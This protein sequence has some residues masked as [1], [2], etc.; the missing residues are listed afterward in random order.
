MARRASLLFAALLLS[1]ISILA[2]STG[3]VAQPENATAQPAAVLGTENGVKVTSEGCVLEGTEPL[4]TTKS[5]R[6][7]M[8]EASAQG[9]KSN[10]CLD[11]VFER[12]IKTNPEEATKSALAFL[13]C[14]ELKDPAIEAGCHPIAHAIGRG[15]F[16]AVQTVSDS[17]N[18]CDQTCHSGCYHG[19]MER[20]LRGDS[21]NGN[22]HLSP[23]ELTVK[24]KQ[25]CDP[26]EDFQ[27]RFQCLHG[28]GHALMYYLRTPPPERYDLRNSLKICDELGD[29]WSADSCWGGVFMENVSPAE[30][31]L[32]DVT[33]DPH[34]P[35]NALD[36]KYKGSCYQMQTSR[37]FQLGIGRND[38]LGHCRNAGAYRITCAESLGRDISNDV[39]TGDGEGVA[40]SCEAGTE[41]E[42]F[43]CLRGAVR[44]VIDNTWDGRFALPFCPKF[45]SPAAVAHCFEVSLGYLAGVY[46]KS[47]DDLRGECTTHSPGNAGCTD[48]L[49][50]MP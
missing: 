33:D 31:G 22:A 13:A 11:D 43:A 47:K 25:A 30:P 24:A 18:I 49:A 28:L 15:T 10:I 34:Y 32:G 37:M 9:Q 38:I 12:Y 39:R 50:K 2:C 36:E 21:D 45:K 48:A 19:A 1:P 14:S 44:A 26:T 29:A 3:D 17:F 16:A 42:L 23:A 20:F 46:A 41:D 6:K 5:M 27:Y 40:R 4:L 7:C 8:D 35:C